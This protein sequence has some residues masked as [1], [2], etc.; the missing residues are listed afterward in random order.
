MSDKNLISTNHA[1]LM[2]G[3]ERQTLANW[4]SQGKGPAYVR[5]SKSCVKYDPAEVRAFINTRKRG[6]KNEPQ[7]TSA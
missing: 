4:R 1:A 6:S 3:V 7:K 2:L 5:I